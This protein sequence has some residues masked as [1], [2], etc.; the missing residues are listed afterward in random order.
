MKMKVFFSLIE[1]PVEAP[2][3]T[4]SLSEKEN[5]KRK[6]KKSIFINQ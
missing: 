4:F 2:L 1:L 3:E 5:C 6:A